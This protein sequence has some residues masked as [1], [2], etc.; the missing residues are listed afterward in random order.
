[1]VLSKIGIVVAPVVHD[2][3]LC[4]CAIVDEIF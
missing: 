3:E 4:E 2:N 1:M